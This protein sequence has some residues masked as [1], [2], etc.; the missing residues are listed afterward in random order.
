MAVFYDE[1]KR[2]S[3]G[4]QWMKPSDFLLRRQCDGF[5]KLSAVHVMLPVGDECSSDRSTYL[6]DGVHPVA[7]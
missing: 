2:A 1:A 6:D 7:Q 3:G 5:A 4:S